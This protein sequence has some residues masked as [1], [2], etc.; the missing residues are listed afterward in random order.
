MNLKFSP[1]NTPSG[2]RFLY[3]NNRG[4]LEEATIRE[5][6]Q[7]GQYLNWDGKWI[8][9]EETKDFTLI[10]VLRIDDLYTAR[11]DYWNKL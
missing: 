9:I 4:D 6:S 10:E 8:G 7:S 11:K 2:S 1:D 3:R 5:W